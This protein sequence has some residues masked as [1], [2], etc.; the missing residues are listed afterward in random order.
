MERMYRLGPEF[1]DITWSAGGSSSHLTTE[2]TATAQSVYGLETV[3][4]LTCT[5]MP[6]E[7]I[8]KALK[9]IQSFSR[10]RTLFRNGFLHLVY[11]IMHSYSFFS[12]RMQKRL[13]VRIFL[14]SVAIR[15]VDRSIGK[16]VKTAFLMPQILSSTLENSMETILAFV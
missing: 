8:D 1:I 13:G 15:L 9:V 10:N 11:L 6:K 2:I 4:H 12:F 7:K 16:R 14:L 3:M 5:N